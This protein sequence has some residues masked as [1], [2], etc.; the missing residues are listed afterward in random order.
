MNTIDTN[1]TG[2]HP[3]YL[4]DVGF[5]QN[6]YKEALEGITT[7]LGADSYI[8]SGCVKTLQ[9]AGVW[10]ISDGFVVLDK[11]VFKVNAHTATFLVESDPLYFK[12]TQ[13]YAEPSPVIY[14][15]SGVQNVHINRFAEVSTEVTDWVFGLPTIQV[16][17]DRKNRTEVGFFPLLNSWKGRVAYHVVGGVIHLSGYAYLDS[18]T[19]SLMGQNM[20]NISTQLLPAIKENEYMGT[21]PANADSFRLVYSGHAN[22]PVSV[23]GVDSGT[24]TRYLNTAGVVNIN[25]NPGINLSPPRVGYA[26]LGLPLT[27]DARCNL[28]LVNFANISWL[29]ESK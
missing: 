7:S 9:V 11:E 27:I 15:E 18:P 25:P 10:A 2:G 4:Q 16:L 17:F 26:T 5:L 22:F 28:L 6:A 23:I 21:M 12:I 13:Q 3:L 19:A 1:K 24:F 29:I 8:L 14:K 20:F